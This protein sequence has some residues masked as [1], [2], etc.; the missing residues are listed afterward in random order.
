M[1]FREWEK[2]AKEVEKE[3]RQL[4]SFDPHRSV[5]TASLIREAQSQTQLVHRAMD[6]H[7]EAVEAFSKRRSFLTRNDLSLIQWSGEFVRKVLYFFEMHQKTYTLSMWF[8]LIQQMIGSSP[9]EEASSPEVVTK[10]ESYRSRQHKTRSYLEERKRQLMA[11]SEDLKERYGVLVVATTMRE[12]AGSLQGALG[13]DVSSALHNPMVVAFQYILMRSVPDLGFEQRQWATQMSKMS[14]TV[15]P[16]KNRVSETQ[17]EV[18]MFDSL[19]VA[20]QFDVF[21]SKALG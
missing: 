15:G 13:Q 4:S 17:N 8:K 1:K 6:G 18:L 21:E 20:K 10:L 12:A 2:Q 9:Q 7:L 5:K 11:L 16:M 14:C 19:G 3:L